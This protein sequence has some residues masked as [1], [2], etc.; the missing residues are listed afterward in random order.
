M[1]WFN[2]SNCDKLSS[3][4]EIWLFSFSD[5]SNNKL[6][7]ISSAIVNPTPDL[8]KMYVYYKREYNV[9]YHIYYIPGLNTVTN[10]ATN[11][12]NV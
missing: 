2:Y 7:V 12:A 11:A 3:W 9:L 4:A 6:M 8:M 1:M 5:L 10:T